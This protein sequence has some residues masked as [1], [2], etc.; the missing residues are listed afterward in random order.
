MQPVLVPLSLAAVVAM[1]GPS[2][3]GFHR[4][5]APVGPTRL[6]NLAVQ[7]K[8]KASLLSCRMRIGVY[9]PSLSASCSAAVSAE[10]SQALLTV[11]QAGGDGAM[12]S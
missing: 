2:V 11:T 12:R 10:L 6:L 5:H 8:A 4:G 1:S 3:S 7:G 9:S